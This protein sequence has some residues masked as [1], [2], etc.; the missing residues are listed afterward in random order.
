M[1][2]ALAWLAQILGKTATAVGMSHQRVDRNRA[3]NSEQ[4]NTD[5]ASGWACARSEVTPAP[6]SS[7]M[8]RETVGA[9]L[10]IHEPVPELVGRQGGRQ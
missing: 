1:I 6:R 3:G 4:M 8:R 2:A 7:P 10:A 9:Q 5:H